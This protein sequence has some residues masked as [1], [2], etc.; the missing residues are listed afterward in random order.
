[1]KQCQACNIHI[2]SSRDEAHNVVVD[3]EEMV[4]CDACYMD[5]RMFGDNFVEAR[6]EYGDR[7][8]RLNPVKVG[9]VA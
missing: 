9:E 3:G 7:A 6:R 5:R 1:M 2:N 4:L 8:R